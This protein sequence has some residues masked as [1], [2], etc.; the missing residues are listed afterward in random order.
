MSVY[1]RLEILREK[2]KVFQWLDLIYAYI[3]KILVLKPDDWTN[4]LNN[5]D[6]VVIKSKE[7]WLKRCIEKLLFGQT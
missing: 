5:M 1:N 2:W 3:D 6:Q 4:S 7:N